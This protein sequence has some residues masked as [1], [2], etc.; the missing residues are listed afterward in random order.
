[1]TTGAKQP[2]M[3]FTVNAAGACTVSMYEGATATGGTAMPARNHNRLSTNTPLSS[4]VHSPSAGTPGTVPIVDTRYLPGGASP[5]TRVG[6]AVRSTVEW[7]LGT[8]TKY[9][10]DVVNVSGGTTT[11]SSIF[12]W[13]EEPV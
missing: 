7:M 13:Y 9:L 3:M 12:E 5:T 2:H 11:I 6:G 8:A 10:I 4:F 1:M